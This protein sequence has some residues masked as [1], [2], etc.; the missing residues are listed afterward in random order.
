MSS[1]GKRLLFLSALA[2]IVLATSG[3][4]LLSQATARIRIFDSDFASRGLAAYAASIHSDRISIVDDPVL[5]GARKVAKMTVYDSDTGPTKDPRAQLETPRFWDEGEEYYVGLSVMFGASWDWRMCSAC[6]VTFHQVYG[7]PYNAQGP[8]NLNVKSNN[9]ASEPRMTWERT[10]P[11]G[12]EHPFE[13]AI[14]PRKWYDIVWHEKLS[15]DPSEGFVELW[16]NAG[17]GWSRVKLNGHDRLTMATKIKANGSR[18]D[19]NSSNIQLYRRRGTT[20]VATM[21][22]AEHRVGTSFDAAAP[23]SYR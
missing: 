3:A 1:K 7:P 14:R 13:M 16:I 19:G 17:R 12:F 9:R 11:F 6:W 23:H 5:G 18:L 4:F 22:F 15:R 20:R 8:T 2:G 21:Y 10:Q